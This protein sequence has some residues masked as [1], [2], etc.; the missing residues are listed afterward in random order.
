MFTMS[1]VSFVAMVTSSVVTVGHVVVVA[2]GMRYCCN[3]H[4]VCCLLVGDVCCA[5]IMTFPGMT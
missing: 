4:N 3:G 5:G 1:V 2:M